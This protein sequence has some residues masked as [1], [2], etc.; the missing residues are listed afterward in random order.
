MPRRKVARAAL[1]AGSVAAASAL[2]V[3]AYTTRELHRPHQPAP[4][5]FTLSPFEM[6]ADYEPVSFRTEDG[7]TLRGWWLPWPETDRVVIGLVEHR[8][9]K[10]ELLG[11]G[12]ALW[13]AGDSVL[14][15]DFRGCGES[16]LAPLSVGYN[17]LPD[18][19]AAVRYA[20][21]RLPGARVG[22]LG[23]SMGAVVAILT[24][25]DEP[26]V[27][28]VVAD[29]PYASLAD[30]LAYAYRRHHLPRRLLDLADLV[31]RR[32]YGYPFAALRPVDAVSRIAPRPLFLIHG[33]EDQLTPVEHARWLYAA[34]GE[35][36]ELW[37][38]EGAPHCGAYF[39]DRPAYV[40]RVAD[41]FARALSGAGS[42]RPRRMG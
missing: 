35:P 22:L 8:R 21:E 42:E 33:E 14:L 1:T 29:S 20:C 17:E 9:A 39:V 30:V 4:H 25:A 7:L 26:A 34:A 28:A 10:H 6:G 19:R 15:F 11:I 18:A 32:R 23:Y 37:V 38:V 13:R 5:G 24:A 40:A 31:N 27:R 41:F 3:V 2:G 12:T 16:D 36:K